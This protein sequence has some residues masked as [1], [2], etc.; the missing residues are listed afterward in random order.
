[1]HLAPHFRAFVEG[2]TAMEDGREG[3]PRGSDADE[4][5]LQQLFADFILPLEDQRSLT[6]RL[7]RQD[8]LYGQQRLVA[9]GDWGNT[10]RTFEGGKVVFQSPADTFEAFWVRPVVNDIEEPNVGDG[11]V[12]FAGFYNTTRLP[13]LFGPKANSK[14]ETYFFAL[15]ES[16]ASQP[17]VDQ[18]T[19]TVGSRFASA[20]RPW[21]VDVEAN[22]Q[23]GD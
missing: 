12:S 2:K 4:D 20:P 7:G 17:H 15:N 9:P 22:Y 23:F 19:Y 16:P 13:K 6:L 14:I 3:G 18:D 11:N 1:L 8:L 21:D 5:D 10:R